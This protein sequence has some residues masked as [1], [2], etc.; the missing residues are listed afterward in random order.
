M[1]KIHALATIIS[2]FTQ[3]FEKDLGIGLKDDEGYIHRPNR[4]TIEGRVEL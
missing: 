2:L 3:Y 4:N 1:L